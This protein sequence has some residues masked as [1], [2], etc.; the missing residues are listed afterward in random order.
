MLLCV[1][2]RCVG[3]QAMRL[4]IRLTKHELFC[5]RG[6]T[7]FSCGFITCLGL[8]LISSVLWAQ[9]N[10]P[11]SRPP[12]QQSGPW[13]NDVDV[14]R[15]DSEGKLTKLHSFERAGVQYDSPTR[16]T[17]RGAKSD[18]PGDSRTAADS[19]RI[20][21]PQRS[22]GDVFRTSPTRNQILCG[23]SG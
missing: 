22:C 1:C 12:E 23:V 4:S 6:Q 21:A 20:A 2:A 15:A 7:R 14:Y 13:N 3:E 10:V 16:S 5:R 8:W 9:P 19:S 18:Q 11:F 17:S